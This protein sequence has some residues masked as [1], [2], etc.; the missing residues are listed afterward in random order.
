MNMN[1]DPLKLVKDEGRSNPMKV[2]ITY[3]GCPIHG[4][5]FCIVV[6]F[7][8]IAEKCSYLKENGETAE[9]TWVS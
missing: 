4:V 6:G 5:C 1:I 7:G 9:C 3:P 8:A 2:S